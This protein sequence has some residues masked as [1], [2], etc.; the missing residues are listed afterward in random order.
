ME[1]IKPYH[2]RMA[3]LWTISTRRKLTYAE[4]KE[5]DMCMEANAND[6]WKRITLENLSLAASMVQD[7]EWLHEICSDIE[8]AQ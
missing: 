2:Q 3:E 7:T 8:D 4:Q 1:E 6:V 5:L